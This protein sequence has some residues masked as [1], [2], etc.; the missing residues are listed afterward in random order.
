MPS[1]TKRSKV[2]PLGRKADRSL[3]LNKWDMKSRPAGTMSTALD[4]G[5]TTKLSA[6][7]RQQECFGE[8]FCKPVVIMK[9]YRHTNHDIMFDDW[10]A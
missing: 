3:D 9:R 10:W 4:V 6:V 7:S 1:K 2:H 5:E 8:E